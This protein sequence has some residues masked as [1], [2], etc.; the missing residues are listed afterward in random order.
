MPFSGNYMTAADVKKHLYLAHDLHGTTTI[1]IC[2]ENTMAGQVMPIE[3]LQ[4]ISN[5]A[6]A[7]GIF[8]HMDGGE[9]EPKD[10]MF[11]GS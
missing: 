6:R 4:K 3:E 11:V 8:I 5:I 2:V 9:R 10:C 1:G 7:S